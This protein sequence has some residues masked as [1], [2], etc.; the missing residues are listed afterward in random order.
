M[1][2]ETIREL[3]FK[4][5][6]GNYTQEELTTFLDSVKNMDRASFMEAYYLLYQEIDKY[7]AEALSP[8]F[9]DQLE[10]RLDLLEAKEDFLSHK[11]VV[12]G[13]KWWSYAAAAI[14][15]FFVT[16]YFLLTIPKKQPTII[17]VQPV[18]KDIPAGR[19]GAILTL[20]T[21]RRIVLDSAAN[22]VLTRDAGVQ[23]IRKG[24]ELSYGGKADE[25]L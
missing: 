14:L 17:A 16:G 20:S 8:G 4:I 25:L 13:R 6:A 18:K 22:G 12:F 19:Q 24:G 10:S 3:I 9:K 7:P 11:T 15:L 21:G 1:P 2:T 23:V 5:A